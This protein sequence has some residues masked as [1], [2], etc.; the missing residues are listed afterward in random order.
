MQEFFVRSSGGSTWKSRFLRRHSSA[1]SP[2]SAS[3]TPIPRGSI[4]NN[5]RASTD[6]PPD[7]LPPLVVEDRA[8][9]NEAISPTAMLAAELFGMRELWNDPSVRTAL[10]IAERRSEPSSPVIRVDDVPG[11]YVHR[12]RRIVLNPD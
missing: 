4:E 6:R 5:Y 7:S 11:L 3:S 8:N 2:T 10:T 9:K 1:R 12:S